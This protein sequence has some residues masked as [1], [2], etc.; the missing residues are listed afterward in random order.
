MWAGKSEGISLVWGEH[1]P[2]NDSEKKGCPA[3][4]G[5]KG[6][7]DCSKGIKEKTVQADDKRSAAAKRGAEAESE[8]TPQS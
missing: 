7:S 4:S 8:K 5:R 1:F 2:L 3:A 6:I